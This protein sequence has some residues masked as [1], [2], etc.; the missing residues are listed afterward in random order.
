MK[1]KRCKTCL[2]ELHS[3]HDGFELGHE[4]DCSIDPMKRQIEIYY[5]DGK[6]EY[7]VLR[8]DDPQ[9][10]F[11]PITQNGMLDLLR[12]LRRYEQD[13]WNEKHKS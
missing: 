8:K 4:S 2:A 11:H 12:N 1:F 13:Y 9:S 7:V 5:H 3:T 10:P 6:R